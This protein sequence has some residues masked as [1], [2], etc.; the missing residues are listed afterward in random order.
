[1]C[2]N[3]PHVRLKRLN[4]FFCLFFCVSGAHYRREDRHF[5]PLVAHFCYRSGIN[6]V[7]GIL[8]RICTIRDKSKAQIQCKGLFTDLNSLA[9]LTNH[10]QNQAIRCE[11]PPPF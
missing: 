5:H 6:N 11:L 8:Y 10:P 1:M 7:D 9:S 3:S 2:I 4:I